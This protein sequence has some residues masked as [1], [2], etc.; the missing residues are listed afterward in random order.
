MRVI[1]QKIFYYTG[2]T[3]RQLFSPERILYQI[4]HFSA[5]YATFSLKK[6]AAEM[7]EVTRAMPDVVSRRQP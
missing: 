2:I 4:V 3:G 1:P 5:S 6:P 7:R